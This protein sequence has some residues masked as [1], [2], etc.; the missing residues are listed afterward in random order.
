LDEINQVIGVFNDRVHTQKYTIDIYNQRVDRHSGEAATWNV[1]CADHRF[2][3]YDLN[4]IK[5]DLPFSIDQYIK[6]ETGAA[7]ASSTT[8]PPPA[9]PAGPPPWLETECKSWFF[10]ICTS[11]YTVAEQ[12]DINARKSLESAL[13][14]PTRAGS[15]L[16]L[17]LHKQVRYSNGL[18]LIEDPILHGITTLPATIGWSVS[19]DEIMGVQVSFGSGDNGSLVDLVPLGTKISKSTCSRISQEVGAAVLRLTSGQ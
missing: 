12:A 2:F 13:R 9:A 16:E 3:L 14:D 10:G 8:P 5:A 6:R 11:H 1:G 18:L 15:V 17:R 7:P 4:S 19:C